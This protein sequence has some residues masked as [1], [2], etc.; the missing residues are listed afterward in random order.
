MKPIFYTAFILTLCT[1]MAW[2]WPD[3]DAQ[4]MI[5]E[6]EGKE[7]M[8]LT[9]VSSLAEILEALG[10]T[11]LPHKVQ[12][13]MPLVSAAVGEELVKSGF[14][15]GPGG[16]KMTKQSKHFVCTSC[17]NIEKED[18]DLSVSDPQARLLYV[19]DKGLPFLQGTTLYGAVNRTSFYNGDY[20]KKY[21]DLV[22]EAQNDIRSA[23]Q[24]C[25]E[26]CAQ[27][28]TLRDWEIE[29][30]LAYLWTIDLKVKDLSL[31]EK[32]W[33]ALDQAL[34]GNGNKQEMIN[35]LKQKYLAGSPAT[36][37]TPPEDRKGG[38]PYEG[39][40]ENGK[41][42]YELSCLHCHE[43]GRYAFYRLDESTFSF[44]HLEHHFPRYTRYSVYQ[45]A[46]YGTSPLNGKRAYMPNYTQE[47]MSNQ[48][49][50]DL[51]AYVAQ[52][53]NSPAH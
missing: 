17:H 48:Q 4:S 31:K 33:N 35:L 39:N 46:R 14:S 12:T 38:Y 40:A 52:M 50:E 1:W 25:A 5:N 18:P 23:I 44:K 16:L 2:R 19:K 26:E 30:I 13:E 24:L 29:S 9:T 43:N 49:M 28:R 22:S 7:K 3:V 8:V 11:P 53:L 37:I 6:K 21:G 34:I 41:L 27:G 15:R 47:K 42:I 36:F 10:D 45:V 32:E 20:R 51:R